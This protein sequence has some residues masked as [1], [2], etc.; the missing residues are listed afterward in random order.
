MRNPEC[1]LKKETNKYLW[2]FNMNT[3]N[4][5]LPDDQTLL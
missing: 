3:D 1:I 2:D 5:I 4:L